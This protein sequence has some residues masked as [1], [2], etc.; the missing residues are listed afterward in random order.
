M[1]KGAQFVV[2]LLFETLIHNSSS[3]LRLPCWASLETITGID[4]PNN[5]AGR[6]YYRDYPWSWGKQVASYLDGSKKL[7]HARQ[8]LLA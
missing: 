7:I 1:C 8:L 4:L 3:F 5:L 6:Y 2:F